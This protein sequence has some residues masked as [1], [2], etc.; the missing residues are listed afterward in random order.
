MPFDITLTSSYTISETDI[1]Y[2]ID[3]SYSPES[4][5]E[6]LKR[7]NAFWSSRLKDF[8][9]LSDKEVSSLDKGTI[10][11]ASGTLTV[12]KS[13]FIIVENSY[14]ISITTQDK[15]TF[16]IINLIETI[17]LDSDATVS[18]PSK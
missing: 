5:K 16:R 8:K 2:V 4:L 1:Y 17:A 7:Q 9:Y 11:K 13:D 14:D 3:Y 10:K 15:K 18:K 6:L 12:R